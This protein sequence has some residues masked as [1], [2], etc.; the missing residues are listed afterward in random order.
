LGEKILEVE[1]IVKEMVSSEPMEKLIS[2][3]VEEHYKGIIKTDIE[4]EKN[5]ILFKSLTENFLGLHTLDLADSEVSG[6][7]KLSSDIL[8]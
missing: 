5:V 3:I 6:H 7:R 4:N 8:N 1:K 2:G